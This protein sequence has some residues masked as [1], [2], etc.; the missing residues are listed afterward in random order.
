LEPISHKFEQEINIRPRG[1]QKEDFDRVFQS[2]H[3]TPVPISAELTGSLLTLN[4]LLTLKEGDIIKLE[5]KVSDKISI[6]LAGKHK[7]LGE[8]VR[9]QNRKGI[10]VVGQVLVQTT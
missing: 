5:Q 3:L 10:R 8:A 4:D 9:V 6:L 1:N 7:Y 2:L